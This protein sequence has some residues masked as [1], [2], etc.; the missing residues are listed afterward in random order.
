MDMVCEKDMNKK[1][2][3]VIV[4]VHNTFLYVKECLES[5]LNQTYANLEV[6]CIDSSTD[7]TIEILKKIACADSRVRLILDTNSSYGY[8]VNKGIKEAQGDFIAIVDSDDY[9][10]CGM[11]QRLIDV[12]SENDADFVKSDHS[13]FFVENKKNVIYEYISN[14]SE[15]EIYGKCIDASNEP[16]ILYKTG[17]SIWTGLYKKSFLLENNIFMNESPGASFQ[18]AGFSVL[19]HLYGRKIYY[20]CESFYRYRTD[21]INS[22]VKSPKKYETIAEEWKWIEGQIVERKIKDE[23]ILLAL[24]ARKLTN[25]EWNIK[26]LPSD[27]AVKFA[28]IINE[29]LDIQYLQSNLVEKMPPYYQEMFNRVYEK[30]LQNI[31]AKTKYIIDLLRDQ[32]VALVGYGELGRKILSY[33]IENGY[34]GIQKFYDL[35]DKVLEIDG[36]YLTV[37][38]INAR[39]VVKNYVYLIADAEHENELYNRLMN[40][41]VKSEQVYK[42]EQFYLPTDMS[43]QEDGRKAIEKEVKEDEVKVSIIVPVYNVERYLEECLRSLMGQD[44]GNLEIICVDDGSTDGSVAI[45]ERMHQEDGRIKVVTQKNQGLA[46]ARNTGLRYAHGKYIMFCDSDDM[47]KRNSV[48]KLHVLAEETQSQIVLFDAKCIYMTEELAT[49]NNKDNYYQ[50]TFSYGLDNGKE[51]FA[52]MMEND[53][54]CDSACLMFI[55]REWIISTDLSF[56]AGILYEDCLF[57]V[58]CMMKAEKVYHINEQFY[59]YRVR[60]G[61]IMT[62]HANASNLYGRLINIHNFY[63]IFFTENLTERQENALA[64]FTR[65]VGY[66]AKWLAGSMEMSE[67]DKLLCMKL[68]PFMKLELETYGVNADQ[69]R[70]MTR[71]D[72]FDQILERAEWIEIYGAGTRGRR[73]LAYL[74]LKGHGNKICNFVVTTNGDQQQ[75]IDG[76][77]VLSV[78]EGWKPENGKLLIIS[79]AGKEAEEVYKRYQNMGV[80]DII[81]FDD[82]IN[83]LVVKYLRERLLF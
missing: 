55:D 39:K 6:I 46:A 11:L 77:N 78:E 25:Y 19:T 28:C 13:S 80:T 2:I 35:E 27:L 62:S 48:R 33:D 24:R 68:T 23:N 36:L 42:A 18:D 40:T 60:E 22:S 5:I 31:P 29:E 16:S 64:E 4:P 20:L 38:A 50:R 69:I 82:D 14:A 57:S 83:Y 49:K 67:I 30:G 75:I 52:Q 65:T 58:Q 32:Q 37:N 15:K 43:R 73:L 76:I 74:I 21:N 17:I 45:L 7:R 26:R 8:K 66:H 59:I 81:Q 9:L 51:M 79:F 72:K 71:K 3:S 61:S 10:E 56:Y 47:L 70:R 1:M 53:S 54:Y 63:R 41:G 34:F 12:I 44:E